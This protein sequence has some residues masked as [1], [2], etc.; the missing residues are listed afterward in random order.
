MG[1]IT[2]KNLSTLRNDIAVLIAS[3]AVHAFYEYAGADMY[4]AL[5]DRILEDYKVHITVRVVNLKTTVTITDAETQ[6]IKK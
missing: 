4:Q 1:T 3:K 5:K 2:I 6:G